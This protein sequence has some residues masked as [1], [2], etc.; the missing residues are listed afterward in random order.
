M[1]HL[2][3]SIRQNSHTVT[4]PSLNTLSSSLPSLH[5]HL[6]IL[7]LF[8]AEL[9]LYPLQHGRAPTRLTV[10][11]LR[12]SVI[13]LNLHPVRFLFG[14]IS[15][16]ICSAGHAWTALDLR[17]GSAGAGCVHVGGFYAH[18]RSRDD[19][20]DADIGMGERQWGIRGMVGD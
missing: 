1:H 16:F 10:A 7:C 9:S 18:F 17:F 2:C 14:A 8:I 4:L 3:S 15:P 20:R 5:S 6:H 11:P 13:P 12:S 19:V